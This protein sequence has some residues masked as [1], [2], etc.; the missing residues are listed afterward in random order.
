[1]FMISYFGLG[2]ATNVMTLRIEWPSGALQE[3]SN[4]A[5]N[6][7]HTIWE[8]PAMKAAIQEDGACV[9]MVT[10]EPNRA[11]RIE[12]SA[13][14]RTWQELGTVNNLTAT[15]GYT[16]SASAHMSSRFYRVVAK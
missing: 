2:N 3:L 8:P 16:D 13:D 12:G 9:L 4:L 5:V 10:A 6:Q 1:M 14:L 15:F 11:W 7:F